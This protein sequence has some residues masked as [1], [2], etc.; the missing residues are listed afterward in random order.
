MKKLVIITA[1]L[2]LTS[3]PVFAQPQYWYFATTVNGVF[4]YTYSFSCTSAQVSDPIYASGNA[5]GP[6]T[7][8]KSANTARQQAIE[9]AKSRGDA[10]RLSLGKCPVG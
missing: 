1:L 4:V 8:I 2:V 5:V 6:F 7:D 10:L 9:A 3:T